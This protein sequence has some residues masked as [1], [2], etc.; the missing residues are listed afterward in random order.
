M[1]LGAF[2]IAD[3]FYAPVAFRFR[4]YGVSPA[5]AAR[6]YLRA[7]L[8]LPGMREWEA[9]GANDERLADHDLDKLYPN[10]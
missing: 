7:L 2:T 3:A 4:T 10:D 6:D 1:L 9:A 8:E 5:G